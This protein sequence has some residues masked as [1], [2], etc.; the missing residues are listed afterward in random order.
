MRKEF[1]FWKMPERWGLNEAQKKAVLHGEGPAR[2]LAGPGSGKTH[3]IVRRL[4]MLIK[5]RKIPPE[6]ILVLTFTRAAA[7]QMQSRFLHL[8]GEQFYPVKFAT[9]HSFFYYV[10]HFSDSHSA[11][12]QDHS[13]KILS[14]SEKHSLIQQLI[15]EYKHNVQSDYVPSIEQIIHFIAQQKNGC[16]AEPADPLHLR[17]YFW[18]QEKYDEKLGRLKKLDLDDL[19]HKCVCLLQEDTSCRTFW[20]KRFPYLLVDEFQDINPMQYKVLRLLAGECANLFVVGDDDQSIYGFRGS[21]PFLLRQF[22]KDYP[23]SARI[24]LSYNYRSTRQI[25]DTAGACICENKNRIE[26]NIQAAGDKSTEN[27]ESVLINEVPDMEREYEKITD[28]I[29]RLLEEGFMASEIAL[30]TR[31]NRELE[32]AA[33]HLEKKRIPY[34]KSG[35]KNGIFEHFLWKDLEACLKI[36]CKEGT[37]QD[38]LRMQPSF[39][40]KLP[41][42][43]FAEENLDFFSLEHRLQ[44]QCEIAAKEGKKMVEKEKR[45]QY[46]A[47]MQFKKHCDRLQ[48]MLPKLAVNYIRKGMGYEQYL[49]GC[50]GDSPEELERFMRQLDFYQQHADTFSDIKAWLQNISINKDHTGPE[51]TERAGVWLL[52]M[53]G[54]KGLEFPVVILPDLN[55]GVIPGK[56]ALT[57]SDIEEERRMLYVAMTRAKKKLYL[58]YLT[59]ENGRKKLPSRFLMPLLKGRKKSLY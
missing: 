13:L 59:G 29:C 43:L 41:R 49:Q 46:E 26:K 7:L 27:E 53:H 5:E 12:G 56:N 24:L 23:Q 22:V 28:H 4:E 16:V 57:E 8:M 52:T 55:E 36:A 38:F 45:I 15:F 19:A 42:M 17:T 35:K 51:K 10:L 2:V 37:T 54:S 50:H 47:L 40:K 48:R 32:E 25:L 31:T 33:V 39:L 9:F 1:L 20:Q 11:C 58:Y 30:I 44:E 6:S 18:F 21:D 34:I 3:V 14:E